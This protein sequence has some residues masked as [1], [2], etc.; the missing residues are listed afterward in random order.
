MCHSCAVEAATHGASMLDQTDFA[1]V[2]RHI[3]VYLNG[4]EKEGFRVRIDND[5]SAFAATRSEFGGYVHPA[6]DPNLSDI[7]PRSGL[8]LEL[9]LPDRRL[10][11]CTAVRMFDGER[12]DQLVWSRRLWGDRKPRLQPIVPITLKWPRGMPKPAG[13]LVYSGGLYLHEDYRANKIGI[14]LVRLL[15]AIVFRDW[16]PDWVF[17][18]AQ[19]GLA[20]GNVPVKHYGY[21]RTVPCFDETTDFGPKHVR[22]WLSTM[23]LLDMQAEYDGDP[24]S[25][26]SA[27]EAPLLDQRD[28]HDL[29]TAGE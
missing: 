21:A 18:L 25:P 13:R 22:E 8:W 4:I 3:K 11:G 9:T 1:N 26:P 19:Q 12:L 24:L 29:A 23:S 14:R 20:E 6:L 15:R 16:A 10:V 7:P 28:R 2:N 27:R 5:L 17:G